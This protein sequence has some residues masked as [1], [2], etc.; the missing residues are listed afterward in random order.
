LTDPPYNVRIDGHVR[1]K[2]RRRFEAFA[3]GS[4]E[5]SQDAF[6]LFLSQAFDRAVAT[7]IDGAIAMVFMDWRH[8]AD[9]IPAGDGRFSEL[10]NL[11]V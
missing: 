2:G 8:L 1:G 7:M 10:L 6:R 3:I 5:L 9:A 11:G 4:G